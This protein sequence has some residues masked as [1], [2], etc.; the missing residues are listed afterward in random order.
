MGRDKGRGKP[1]PIPTWLQNGLQ[2][3]SK[4]DLGRGL[5]RRNFKEKHK[6]QKKPNSL[7]PVP[8][9]LTKKDAT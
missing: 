1:L 2:N 9:F 3:R 8:S 4:M 7:I 6:S 5:G